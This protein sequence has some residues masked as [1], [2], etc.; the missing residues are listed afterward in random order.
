MIAEFAIYPMGQ[1]H[2]SQI[3]ADVIQEVKR[4]GLDF[5]LGPMGT[6]I[7]GEAD[8]LFDIIQRCYQLVDKSYD[9]VI[10]QVTFDNKGLSKNHVMEGMVNSLIGKMAATQEATQS[11]VSGSISEKKGGICG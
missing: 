10:M 8:Q 1:L 11:Q 9:R 3:I 7:E 4:A 6:A 5:R 2:Y